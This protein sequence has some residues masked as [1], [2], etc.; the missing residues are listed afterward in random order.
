MLVVLTRLEYAEAIGLAVDDFALTAAEMTDLAIVDPKAW[1]R[2]VTLAQYP[3]D[4]QTARWEMNFRGVVAPAELPS[5]SWTAGEVDGAIVVLE[6][7][8]MLTDE[9]R[10][11]AT[12][13]V[14]LAQW[15]SR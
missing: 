15:R 6:S 8:G 2:Q 14:S 10:E 13:G 7:L 11:A 1:A 5:R 4:D 12:N 3:K 9:A